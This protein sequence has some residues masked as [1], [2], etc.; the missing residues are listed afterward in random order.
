MIGYSPS[1]T[2]VG[3]PDVDMESVGSCPSRAHDYGREHQ[4]QGNKRV[5]QVAATGMTDS[6]GFFR[7]RIR[8]FAMAE[9][10]SFA[11]RERNKE[12]ARTRI[13]KVKST[14]QSDQAHDVEK[15]LVFSNLLTGPARHW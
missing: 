2:V 8:I 7:Y 4:E 14:F 9:L 3:M 11:G 5:L 12:P 6:G 1:R 15:G 10:K 13:S